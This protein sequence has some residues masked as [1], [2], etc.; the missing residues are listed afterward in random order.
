[1]V[2][3]VGLS[4]AIWATISARVGNLPHMRV[5]AMM[6]IY[7][8]HSA[9][10]DLRIGLLDADTGRSALDDNGNPATRALSMA[11]SV[12]AGYCFRIC[13]S[14]FGLLHIDVLD[15]FFNVLDKFFNSSSGPHRLLQRLLGRHPSAPGL[16]R[17]SRRSKRHPFVTK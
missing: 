12:Q 6:S 5:L 2:Q 16:Q 14:A 8:V 11:E 15:K 3:C 10:T 9:I 13:R 1:M 4:R 7:L 17:R